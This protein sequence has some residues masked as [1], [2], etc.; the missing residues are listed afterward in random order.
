[1]STNG[2]IDQ[3]AAARQAL[4]ERIA[5]M[6]TEVDKLGAGTLEQLANAYRLVV[7]AQMPKGLPSA[8]QRIR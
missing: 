8:P 7:D 4:L 3:Q 6:A 2:E 5:R 1:M